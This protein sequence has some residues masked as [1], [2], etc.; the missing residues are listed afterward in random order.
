MSSNTPE[1][2]VRASRSFTQP[3]ELIVISRGRWRRARRWFSRGCVALLAL[4]LLAFS[5]PAAFG[6]SHSTMA[7][8]AMSGSMGR[9]SVVFTKP[10]PV[11][12]LAIGDVIT[13]RL[14][15]DVDGAEGRQITRRIADIRA[16]EI[17]TSSDRTGAIDPWTIGSGKA[18]QERAVGDVPYLGYLYDA[19]SDGADLLRRAFSGLS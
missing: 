12:D 7:D 15:P 11:A 16:G 5:V 2:S 1:E 9:G 6:L 8:D 3:L 13:Y 4:I 14:P 19:S 17:W 18:M 10:C